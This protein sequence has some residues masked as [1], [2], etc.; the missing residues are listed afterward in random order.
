MG[1]YALERTALARGVPTGGDA[2][3]VFRMLL[4]ICHS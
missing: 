3:M 1:R 2:L 4:S